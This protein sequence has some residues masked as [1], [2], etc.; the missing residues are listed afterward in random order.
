M[1]SIPA[2]GQILLLRIFSRIISIKQYTFQNAESGLAADYTKRR[3]I[4]RVRAEGEQFLLQAEAAR[5]L[6]D[7]IEVSGPL[8]RHKTCHVRKFCAEYFVSRPS[9]L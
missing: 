4:V 6:V 2:A 3:N 8:L 5:N 1:G 9:N 7:W